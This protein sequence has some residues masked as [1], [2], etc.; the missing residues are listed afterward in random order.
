MPLLAILF[1]AAF[2]VETS[3]FTH[4]N[5]IT[6]D[7]NITVDAGQRIMQSYDLS[8]NR[9]HPPLSKIIATLPE[10]ILKKTLNTSFKKVPFSPVYRAGSI[11]LGT[12]LIMLTGYWAMRMWNAKAGLIALGLTAFHPTIQANAGLATPD[13]ALTLFWILTLYLLWEHTQTKKAA[14]LAAAGLALGCAMLSK[15]SALLLVPTLLLIVVIE[16]AKEE[17]GRRRW[18]ELVKRLT[19]L[20]GAGCFVILICY[21]VQIAELFQGILQQ[22]RHAKDGH[23][24]YFLG[25]RSREG[26]WYYF[27]VVFILKNQAGTLIL[28]CAGLL[29][30]QKKMRSEVLLYIVLPCALLLGVMMTGRVN[31]GVRYILPMFPL[32]AIVAGSFGMVERWSVPRAALIAGCLVSVTATSI[33][34]LPHQLAF[35]NEFFGGPRAAKKFMSDS[36]LDWGQDMEHLKQYLDQEGV[37]TITLAPFSPFPPARFGIRAQMLPSPFQ[38]LREDIINNDLKQ[39]LAISVT[40]LHGQYLSN[41][42]TYDW[43]F[44]RKP[45]AQ[46]GNSIL[47]YNI[48][49]DSDAHIQ[50]AQI[51]K[52]NGALMLAT[53]E[54]NKINTEEK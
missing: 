18:Q 47:V 37:S 38:S 33:A 36:N 13:M 43:L 45:V 21:N 39:L 24:A 54:Q 3:I 4:N 26:W 48:T 35:M 8:F 1:V 32:L 20:L 42:H 44:T 7:E 41:P 10:A 51:Y 23:E 19:I 5:A 9:E 15:F 46:I 52:Q 22:I 17:K 53:A 28:M 25:M 29:T 31:I 34:M 27:P 12:C 30:L 14:Y 16:W 2:I 11:I 40:A 50:L 49:N 6:F